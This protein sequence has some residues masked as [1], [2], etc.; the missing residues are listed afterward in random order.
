MSLFVY[1]LES[2]N[3]RVQRSRHSG[4]LGER[5]ALMESLIV[6]LKEVRNDPWRT[7]SVI[8]HLKVYFMKISPFNI[9]LFCEIMVHL[10]CLVGK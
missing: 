3:Y 2:E 7:F 1:P 10:N 5:M 6:M 4:E 8:Q 9:L